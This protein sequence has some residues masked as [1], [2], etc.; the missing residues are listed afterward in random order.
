MW[1]YGTTFQLTNK[2]ALT[3]QLTK[4]VRNGE[5]RGTEKDPDKSESTHTHTHTYRFFQQNPWREPMTAGTRAAAK[6]NLSDYEET[7]TSFY[8]AM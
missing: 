2:Q 4:Y 3:R 7:T 1:L 5:G 8:T 6:K